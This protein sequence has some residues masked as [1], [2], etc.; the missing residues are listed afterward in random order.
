MVQRRR[1][2]GISIAIIAIVTG[3][4]L[5]YFFLPQQ[6]VQHSVIFMG[7]AGSSTGGFLGGSTLFIGGAMGTFDDQSA[8]LSGDFLVFNN[9][10]DPANVKVRATWKSTALVSYTRFDDPTA[11]PNF[12]NGMLVVTVDL[13]LANATVIKGETLTVVVALPGTVLP[14]GFQLPNNLKVPGSYVYLT[15]GPINFDIPTNDLTMFADP[16]FSS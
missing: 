11:G 10:I 2:I 6:R 13:R 7:A 8:K 9:T 4:T 14:S 3:A 12:S 5:A 15:G 1:V 16:S